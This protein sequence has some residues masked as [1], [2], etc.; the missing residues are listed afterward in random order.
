MYGS[1][2]DAEANLFTIHN[3][4][5]QYPC[6]DKPAGS[7]ARMMIND[8]VFIILD[9]WLVRICYCKYTHFL[10]ATEKKIVGLKKSCNFAFYLN[11][12]TSNE[13]D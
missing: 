6:A 1:P 10:V 13:K 5:L 4:L 11:T 7:N 2:L 3:T 12:I 9:M 8:L